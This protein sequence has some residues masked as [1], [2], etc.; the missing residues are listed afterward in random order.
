MLGSADIDRALQVKPSKSPCHQSLPETASVL[1]LFG[2]VQFTQRPAGRF[3]ESNH[4]LAAR[5][6]AVFQSICDE[7]ACRRRIFLELS[8]GLLKGSGHIR[9]SVGVKLDQAGSPSARCLF[10][11]SHK[12]PALIDSRSTLI[13]D[14]LIVVAQPDKGLFRFGPAIRTGNIDLKSAWRRNDWHGVL[15]A[16]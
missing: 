14:K 7:R 2:L 12:L 4:R 5:L 11:L 16:V 6:C 10:D 13:A 1:L 8:A 9:N 3:I 15:A